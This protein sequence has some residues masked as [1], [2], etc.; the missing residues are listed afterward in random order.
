VRKRE[1]RV[2]LQPVRKAFDLLGEACRIDGH[3]RALLAWAD[4]VRPAGVS[5]D[6]TVV[7]PQRG[8]LTVPEYRI[9]P[10]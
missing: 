2:G 5:S 9:T 3:G 7:E 6:E 10:Y 1:L 8:C 4:P